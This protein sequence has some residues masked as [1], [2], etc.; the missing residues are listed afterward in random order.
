MAKKTKSLFVSHD[1]NA[2]NDS[3]IIKLRMEHGWHGYGLWWALVE[4]L[5]ETGDYQ[6]SADYKT[7]AFGLQS[8]ENIVKSIIEDFNLFVVKDGFFFS[9]SLRMRMKIKDAE[10]K[11]KSDG[12]K[13]GNEIRWSKE[14]KFLQ[15]SQS[16]REAERMKSVYGE[17]VE[18]DPLRNKTTKYEV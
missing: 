7:L 17:E 1:L 18:Q 15:S 4:M 8:E 5:G 11:K 2:R 13:K 9:K 3:K 14:T 16:T 12:G 10:R 6:L